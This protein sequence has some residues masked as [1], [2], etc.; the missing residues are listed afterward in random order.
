MPINL[1]SFIIIIVDE[2]VWERGVNRVLK[3]FNFFLYVLD[4]F[5][6]LISKIIYK[7]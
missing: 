6:V 1:R 5:D 2:V 4:R 7:K 3:K